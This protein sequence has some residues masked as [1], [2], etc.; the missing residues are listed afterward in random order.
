MNRALMHIVLRDKNVFIPL[1]TTAWSSK[2]KW[3][4][5]KCWLQEVSCSWSIE[6]SKGFY[7]LL[8][9]E[10]LNM[11]PESLSND[12]LFEKERNASLLNFVQL[13]S[14]TLVLGLDAMS[15]L[16][17]LIFHLQESRQIVLH[18]FQMNLNLDSW[19]IF[20]IASSYQKLIYCRVMPRNSNRNL[21]LNELKFHVDMSQAR[22]SKSL[23]DGHKPWNI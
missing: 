17:W 23:C 15:L 2:A 8:K 20:D 13:S 12:W 9:L 21:Y 6:S 5:K 22:C 1:A 3:R 10:L 18:R 16:F 4:W 19:I 11:K 7:F 14:L